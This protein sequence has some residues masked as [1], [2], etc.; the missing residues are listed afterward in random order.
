MKF[1][2]SMVTLVTIGLAGCGSMASMSRTYVEPTEGPTA[3]IRVVS[4]GSVR[5]MPNRNCVDWD[6][7]D[8]GTVVSDATF[9]GKS[10]THNGKKMGMQGDKPNANGYVSAEVLVRADTPL[11]MYFRSDKASGDW[12]YWCEPMSVAFIPL[13]GEEYEVTGEMTEYCRLQAKSLTRPG[14]FPAQKR[15]AACK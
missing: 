4:N 10:P 9:F 12:R 13:A 7:P 15:V 3:K 8:V 6:S 11:T 1:S 2:A 5:F 14:Q